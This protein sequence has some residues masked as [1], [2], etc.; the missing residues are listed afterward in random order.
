MAV[1]TIVVQ[2]DPPPVVSAWVSGCY[3]NGPSVWPVGTV[4][5]FLVLLPAGPEMEYALFP[6]A[7]VLYGNKGFG[8]ACVG[9]C[10][11]HHAVPVD[12]VSWRP[13]SESASALCGAPRH[14]SLCRSAA[15]VPPPLAHSAKFPNCSP[16]PFLGA[17][18]LCCPWFWC[19]SPLAWFVVLFV[20]CL[21]CFGCAVP[22][23]A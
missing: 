10:P 11:L 15:C 18:P 1:L 22:T 7:T 8:P 3:R 17:P 9:Y 12:R 16:L 13:P 6:F 14:H 2:R 19:V 21:L 23:E 20:S 4:S 5:C